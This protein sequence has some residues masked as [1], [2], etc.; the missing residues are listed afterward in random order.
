VRYV[1][2]HTFRAALAAHV[3]WLREMGRKPAPAGAP[4]AL[5]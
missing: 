4:R 1:A 3:S 2:H 5:G